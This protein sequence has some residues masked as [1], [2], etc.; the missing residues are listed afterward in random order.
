M[1]ATGT[2]SWRRR[3]AP[4]AAAW[5]GRRSAGTTRRQPE[6]SP[7]GA[8][9]ARPGAL[10]TRRSPSQVARR[11]AAGTA[12]LLP[13][14][15]TGAL[16][17][18]GR[19]IACRHQAGRPPGRGGRGASGRS[20]PPPRGRRAGCWPRRRTGHEIVNERGRVAAP[21]PVAG[22]TRWP[23]RASTWLALWRNGRPAGALQL[24]GRERVARHLPSG[25]RPAPGASRPTAAASATSSTGTRLVDLRSRRVQRLPRS[26]ASGRRTARFAFLQFAAIA[27]PGLPWASSSAIAPARTRRRSGSLPRRVVSR[28][29]LAGRWLR[30]AVGLGAAPSSRPLL[31]PGRRQRRA[32]AHLGSARRA[33]AGLVP[34]RAAA[35]VHHLRSAPADPAAAAPRYTAVDRRRL[36]DAPLHRGQHDRGQTF[37]DHPV[38]ARRRP[39]GGRLRR[40]DRLHRLD[41][42]R[43]PPARRFPHH[44]RSPLLGRPGPPGHRTAPPSRSSIAAGS[45][46]WAV[47]A[48]REDS[49]PAATPAR[50]CA[51]SPGRRM[52]DSWPSC[53]ARAS[54]S[55]AWTPRPAWS[56]GSTARAP[57][58]SPDGSRI[59]ISA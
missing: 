46:A 12:R 13:G 47:T 30:P 58:F 2:C 7:D 48:R 15:A 55:S 37:D 59:V 16:S 20:P 44:G 4:G 1:A 31:D 54:T 52:R 50:P 32:A 28:S 36:R 53:A 25:R 40:H 42:H 35:R 18:D 29:S 51:A 9:A 38:F 27:G 21:L 22:P 8:A 49:S 14:A 39:A 6:F 23:G 3:T 43:C 17:P 24:D 57:S 11:R 10:G 5:P 19:L 45:R 56:P 34:R 41:R 26:T 33:R